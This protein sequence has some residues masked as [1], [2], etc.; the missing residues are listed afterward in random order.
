MARAISVM[1]TR[2]RKKAYCKEEGGVKWHVRQCLDYMNTNFV[3]EVSF[4]RDFN[5]LN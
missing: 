4:F 2:K 5:S 1:K 3:S